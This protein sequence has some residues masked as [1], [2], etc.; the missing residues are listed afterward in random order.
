MEDG[1]FAELLNED[2]IPN[3]SN[4]A[5]AETVT[6][7]D[8]TD[9]T[10]SRDANTGSVEVPAEMEASEDSEKLNTDNDESFPMV[11]I[12]YNHEDKHLSI[13]EAATL[14]Q[15][16]MAYEP[17]MD[18]IREL[19]ALRSMSVKDFVASV[20]AAQESADLNRLISECGGNEE[21]AKRLLAVE[22]EKAKAAVQKML[23]DEKADY[24]ADIA[25]AR[26]RIGE[27]YEE[28]RNA[29]PEIKEVKDIPQAV[30]KMAGEKHMPL[31]DA[32]L[33]YQHT[34]RVNAQ[35]VAE[36]QAAAKAA[37]SGSLK[38]DADNG[39]DALVAAMM[40]GVGVI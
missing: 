25:E 32:Y 3:E 6:E 17:T 24:E 19:A 35:S 37:S 5:D 7:N 18:T 20:A 2:T 16:A 26:N 14:S 12:R 10:P 4:E 28:L 39:D 30:I 40:K 38:S 33:R 9:T 29:C 15:K 34:N 8:A 23:D 22:R 21:S 27:Q 1:I 31:L 11:H 36:Q 13:S